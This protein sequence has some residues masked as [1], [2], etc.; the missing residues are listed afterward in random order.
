MGVMLEVRQASF[1]YADGHRVLHGLDLVAERGDILCLLGPN[2]CG[3]STLLRCIAGILKLDSGETYVDGQSLNRRGRQQTARFI[4]YVPQEHAASFPYTVLQVVVMGRAPYLGVFSAPS[5]QDLRIAE[6]ALDQVGISHLRHRRYTEISGGERQLV[7][8]ARVLTQQ[9]SILLLD[10]PTSHLDFGNQML[11]LRTIRRLAR[12]QHLTVVMA[13][14]FPNHA[15]LISSHVS[16][17]KD[18]RFVAVGTPDRVITEDNLELL[19]GIAVRIIA[20]EHAGLPGSV[21]MPLLGV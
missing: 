20:M 17:M 18:G 3:K 9:P 13:T 16:L 10:E 2:G 14:H 19:Y 12:E 1:A 5:R 11:L 4:G 7:L 8:V 21:V 15:L 6:E